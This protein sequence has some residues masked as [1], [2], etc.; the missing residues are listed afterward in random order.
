MQLLGKAMDK[1]N[2]VSVELPRCLIVDDTDL[3]KT[4]RHIELIGNVFSH[5]TQKSVLAFKGLFMGYHDGK[6][7]FV[8]DFPYMVKKEK[9]RKGLLG[10]QQ[11]N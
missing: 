11:N 5:V 8:M 3:P 2:E 6:S 7:F 4:G 9:T 1:D 10:F